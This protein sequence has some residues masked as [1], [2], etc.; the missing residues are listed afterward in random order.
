MSL[1]DNTLSWSKKAWDSQHYRRGAAAEATWAQKH[2]PVWAQS[3][4]LRSLLFETQNSKNWAYDK[5]SGLLIHDTSLVDDVRSSTPISSLIPK[6]F[7]PANP[8]Q[9]NT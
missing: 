2:I 7:K 8:K 9:T 1:R 4:T 3:K 6:L 5:Q